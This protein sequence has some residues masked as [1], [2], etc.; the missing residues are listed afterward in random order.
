MQCKVL[1]YFKEKLR[2]YW[3]FSIILILLLFYVQVYYRNKCLLLLF[4]VI[5]LERG[6][7]TTL[8]SNKFDLFRSS[9]ILVRLQN[10][11][12]SNSFR[13][14]N[15][16]TFGDTSDSWYDRRSPFCIF[17]HK[18]EVKNVHINQWISPLI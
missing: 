2:I 8:P 6:D 16:H 17:K 18:G 14:G 7:L 15:L 12:I 4:W 5:S 1:L 9:Y 10:L 13:T 11:N 3:K